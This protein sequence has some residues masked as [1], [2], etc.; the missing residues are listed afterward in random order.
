MK[1]T[2]IAL[3]ALAAVGS[4]F[5]QAKPPI[6]AYGRL[7]VGVLSTNNGT[8]STTDG[9]TG[10]KNR[11]TFGV[12][13][14][15]DLGGGLTGSAQ[16]EIGYSSRD[17]FTKIG[18]ANVRQAKVGLSGGFG[19]LELGTMWGPYDN[20]S[21]DATGYNRFSSYNQVLNAGAH[22]DNGNGTP[23]GATDGSIQYTTPAFSGFQ[24]V[25]NYA[26]KKVN[27]G[28]GDVD[29]STTAFALTYGAGPL[30]V[31]FGYETTSSSFQNTPGLAQNRTNAWQLRGSYDAG[32]AL[33]S[34]AVIG[35]TVDLAA[36]SNQDAGFDLAA[37]FPMGKWTP[38]LG[39]GSVKTTGVNPNQVDS[40]G[41]QATYKYNDYLD[42]Y[43]GAN[44]TKN[45]AVT[46][47]LLGAGLTLR[48]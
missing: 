32:V 17:A 45:G 18:T 24:G 33:V 21:D 8:T 40:F 47:N 38:A 4:S 43:L 37:S 7:D 20:N 15:T 16:F 22:G 25:I 29:V 14:G 6:A 23:S 41:V 44:N 48:F 30:N 31:A 1:K 12:K 11:S 10:V 3:A 28:A 2:L 42:F 46:T 13:G 19:T 39:F 34:A 35:A 27:L 9:M 36:G 26:P 5:A